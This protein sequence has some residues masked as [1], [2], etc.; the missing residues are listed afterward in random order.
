MAFGRHNRQGSGQPSGRLPQVG[1]ERVEQIIEKLFTLTAILIFP[2]GGFS[3]FRASFLSPTDSSPLFLVQSL[4]YLGIAASRLLKKRVRFRTRWRI[5]WACLFGIAAVGLFTYG[6]VSMASVALL[7]IC[8]LVTFA[9]SRRHGYLALGFTIAIMVA[10]GIAHINGWTRTLADPGAFV[11]SVTAWLHATA[12]LTIGCIAIIIFIVRL[13]DVWTKDIRELSASETRYRRLGTALEQAAEDIIITDLHG[14]IQYV[15]PAFEKITGYSRGEAIGRNPR[16]LKSGMHD[17]EFYKRMWDTI[18]SGRAWA[19]RLINRTKAG[20]LVHLDAIITPLKDPTG[21]IDGF[22]SLKRD[23]TRQVQLEAQLQDSQKMEL[24]GQLAGGIAHD[25]NNILAVILT[26][27]ELSK[28]SLSGEPQVLQYQEQIC[29]ATLRAKE[30]VQQILALAR[31][32]EQERTPFA[33]HAVAEEVVSLIRRVAPA[34]IEVRADIDQDAGTVMGDSGRIHQVLMNLCTNALHAMRSTGGTLAVRLSNVVLE[35]CV[36]PLQPGKHVCLEVR[37][38]GH[39]MDSKTMARIFDPYYT[40]KKPGE[41]TGLGLAVVR[42]IV[43]SHEGDIQVESRLGEGSVFRVYLPTVELQAQDTRGD[44]ELLPRGRERILLIDDEPALAAAGKEVLRQL[45]YAVTVSTR[46]SDGLKLFL[47]NP[48]AFDLVLTD[49]TMPEITGVN[50]A[51]EILSIRS[52]IPVILCTGYSDEMERE[53]VL[54][55]G[56]SDILY[57]PLSAEQLGMAVRRALD[58]RGKT[59]GTGAIAENSDVEGIGHRR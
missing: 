34:T 35:E 19:G 54:K 8:V 16:F 30:L 55:L 13:K 46:S 50:L 11:V 7:W 24:V 20:S 38:T 23:I 42:G 45:G 37:D 53:S 22:V 3:L 59:N 4:L 32:E 29:S 27:A 12:A 9:G 28:W 36:P 1:E 10:A 31:R 6:L 48:E 18:L 21:E 43:S 47:S 39:G 49:Q 2:L 40:T 41:G 52:E 14:L 57:K 56:I 25:F 15:N 44:E 5:F 33:V 58:S 51:R 26:N 17:A